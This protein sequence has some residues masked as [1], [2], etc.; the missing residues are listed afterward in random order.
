MLVPTV[1]TVRPAEADLAYKARVRQLHANLKD[2]RN[3]ELRGDV[4]TGMLAPATAAA[5]THRELESQVRSTLLRLVLGLPP[6]GL[7]PELRPARVLVRTSADIAEV[8]A[9]RWV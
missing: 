3:P 9:Q 7:S 1:W 4:L 2:A 8:V 6:G 5:L